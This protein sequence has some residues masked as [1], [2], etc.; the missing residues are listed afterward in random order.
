[1]GQKK[2]RIGLRIAHALSVELRA[3]P[4]ASGNHSIDRLHFMRHAGTV[5]R[6]AFSKRRPLARIGIVSSLKASL[7]KAGSYLVET[8][9]YLD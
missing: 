3:S 2:T 4:A 5:V 1:L 6:L 8:T 9:V 7:S